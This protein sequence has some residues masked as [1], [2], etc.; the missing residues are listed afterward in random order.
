MAKPEKTI[1]FNFTE[2]EA[3]FLRNGLA[4]L[5]ES[6]DRELEEGEERELEKARTLYRHIGERLGIE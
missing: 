2:T 4:H 6:Y 1:P 3:C 5:I